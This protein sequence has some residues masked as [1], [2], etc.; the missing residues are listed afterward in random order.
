MPELP[1]VGEFVPGYAAELTY[2]FCT[3]LNTPAA[4]KRRLEES[5][6]T[7]VENPTVANELIA[8]GFEPNY[9]IGDSLTQAIASDMDRWADVLKRAGITLSS[10]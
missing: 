8:R 1:T 5:V 6:K 3:P 7:V 9:E 10:Q 4:V 2:S